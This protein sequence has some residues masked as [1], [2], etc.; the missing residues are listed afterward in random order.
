MSMRKN[1]T[2]RFPLTYHEPVIRRQYILVKR[3]KNA[4]QYKRSALNRIK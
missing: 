1:H 4:S 3:L 2:V